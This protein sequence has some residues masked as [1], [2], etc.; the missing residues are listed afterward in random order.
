MIPFEDA[1]KAMHADKSDYILQCEP[2]VTPT[3]TIIRPLSILTAFSKILEGLICDQLSCYMNDIMSM[4]LSA[5]RKRYSCN[6]LLI[7]CIEE[8]RKSL[9]NGE[10]VGC[11]L[12]DLSNAFDSIPHSLLLAK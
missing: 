3:C 5:Y 10:Y 2:D 9:D 7:K 6:N 1:F 12:I 8:I 4:R 11:L